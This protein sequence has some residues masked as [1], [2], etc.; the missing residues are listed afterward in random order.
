MKMKRNITFQKVF[1]PSCEN[2]L[3]KIVLIEWEDGWADMLALVYDIV[4]ELWLL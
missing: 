3:I 4:W 1:F 2:F